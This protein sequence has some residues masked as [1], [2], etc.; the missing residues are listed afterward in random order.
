MTLADLPTRA[1]F[2]HAQEAASTPLGWKAD[3]SEWRTWQP[4][5]TDTGVMHGPCVSAWEQ[6]VMDGYRLPG[7]TRTV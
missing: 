5:P 2:I 4:E 7:T 6:R 3:G 1:E